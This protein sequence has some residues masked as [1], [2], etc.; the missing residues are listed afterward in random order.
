MHFV[1][2]ECLSNLEVT[3]VM[4]RMTVVTDDG[5]VLFTP[6]GTDPVMGY[7]ITGL[8]AEGKYAFLEEIADRLANREQACEFY[9]TKFD[10]FVKYNST[11]LTPEQVEDMKNK[12]TPKPFEIKIKAGTPSYW[13]PSCERPLTGS[14]KYCRSCGQA[15]D[16]KASSIPRRV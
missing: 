11:G 2:D 6:P 8:A 3:E 1:S 15:I 10:E 14:D 7:T 13:C 5:T 4:K 12:Q 16:W 9:E